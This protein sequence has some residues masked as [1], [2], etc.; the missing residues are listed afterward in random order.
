MSTKANKGQTSTVK[1]LRDMCD[2]PPACYRISTDGR[3]WKQLCEDRRN[4][5]NWLAAKADPDGTNIYPGINKIMRV[6]DW[7]HGKTCYVLD[8]LQV[9]GC[10]ARENKEG[11]R[12]TSER[13]TAKRKFNLEPLRAA[14]EQIQQG[15]SFTHPRIHNTGPEIH[16]SP[17]QESKIEK[18]E[19]Q[20]RVGRNRPSYC[21]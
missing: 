9:I 16:D 10:V 6:M 20:R 7:S 4:L 17:D 5:A 14:Y 8:S 21:I 15:V 19:V 3:K 11:E 12:L 2:F 1:C 18:P 13:G